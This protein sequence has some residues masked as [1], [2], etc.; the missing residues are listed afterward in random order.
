MERA[1]PAIMLMADS[2]FAAFRSGIL[3]SAILRTCARVMFA[4]FVLFGTPEPLSMPHYF[5]MRTG[6]GGVLVMKVK[7]RSE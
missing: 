5:L 7:V 3:I 4:T 1:E 2:R 6:V